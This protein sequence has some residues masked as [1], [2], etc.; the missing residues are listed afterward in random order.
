MGLALYAF[1]EACDSG[2]ERADDKELLRRRILDRGGPYFS[3]RIFMNIFSI[4]AWSAV[5][6]TLET[7]LVGENWVMFDAID[8]A[9]DGI[10]AL[11]FD[12]ID[13]AGDTSDA[14]SSGSSTFSTCAGIDCGSLNTPISLPV[15]TAATCFCLC[16]ACAGEPVTSLLSGLVSTIR[17]FFDIGPGVLDIVFLTLCGVDR[18][19]DRGV[20]VGVATRSISSVRRLISSFCFLTSLKNFFC[21]GVSGFFGEVVV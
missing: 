10:W 17:R 14:F 11:R 13:L 20:V 7:D 6:R 9:G 19:V 15:S 4:A 2:V 5:V 1:I 18:G 12:I 21:S 16:V 8:I 3:S